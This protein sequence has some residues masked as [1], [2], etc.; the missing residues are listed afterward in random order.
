MK[1]P[2]GKGFDIDSVGNVTV[3]TDSRF[4]FQGQIKGILD[5]ERKSPPPQENEFLVLEL[6]CYPA[7]V[8]ED[9]EVSII[10]CPIHQ[11]CDTILINVAEIVSI[12]PG[13]DCLGEKGHGDSDD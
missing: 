7:I 8:K 13:S 1:F 4:V 9:A 5:G 12:G 2:Q 11:P 10:Y 3:L 6:R